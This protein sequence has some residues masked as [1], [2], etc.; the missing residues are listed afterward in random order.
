MLLGEGSIGCP[1][2]QLFAMH[3]G[4]HR[5]HCRGYGDLHLMFGHYGGCAGDLPDREPPQVREQLWEEFDEVRGGGPGLQV[6]VFQ[7]RS[8]V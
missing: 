3:Y 5:L 7:V 1:P 2:M 4:I 8:S 6:Q